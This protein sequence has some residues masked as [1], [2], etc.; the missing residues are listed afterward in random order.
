M[1]KFFILVFISISINAFT[2]IPTTNLQG[3]FPF[4]GNANDQSLNSNNGI[5]NGPTLTMDRFG[6]TSS[7][8]SF[9]GQNDWINIGDAP[10]VRINNS[11]SSSVSLWFNG[12]SSSAP[13]QN[14]LRYDDLD[15]SDNDEI[16]LRNIFMLRT[17]NLDGDSDVD[18]EFTF[19]GVAPNL[20]LQTSVYSSDD[21]QLNEWHHV[22][23]IKDFVKDSVFIYMNGQQVLAEKDISNGTWETTNQYMM[24]GRYQNS[25]TSEFFSGSID[26]VRIYDDVLT[27]CEIWALYKEG[28]TGGF[29]LGITQS[30]NILSSNENNA[31]YQW[32]NCTTN[33]SI[34]GETNQSFTG[35]TNVPYAV[36]LNSEMC[37][38]TS[39]CFTIT[40]D[41]IGLNDQLS[42]NL[43]NVYPNP[44]ENSFSIDLGVDYQNIQI[45][46]TDVTGKIILSET[47]NN[48]HFFT[49]QLK[50]P[51]GI[52]MLSVQSPELRKVVRL[53]KQ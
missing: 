17:Q 1:K 38:D 49:F 8:Y 19:G 37:P 33:T 5:V 2:Q 15:N 36:V 32:I 7:A 47:H 35:T 11:S 20:D 40:G 53:V 23:A 14:L 45:I 24:M 26:D 44:I 21:Y 13:Y 4:N 51:A 41:H 22:V 18:I 42:E 50:E 27:K 12:N 39:D 52:Y 43:F 48:G 46:V 25:V 31:S 3:Y 30:G 28:T 9:D 16:N 34:T 10:S 6:N 29:D